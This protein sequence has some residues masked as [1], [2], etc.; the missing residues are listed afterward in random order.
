MT[1]TIFVVGWKWWF[2]NNLEALALAKTLEVNKSSHSSEVKGFYRPFNLSELCDMTR[3]EFLSW[4]EILKAR[5]NLCSDLF[6][7]EKPWR[8]TKEINH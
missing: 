4:L 3:I 5:E 1:A 2:E 6:L 8:N 7:T